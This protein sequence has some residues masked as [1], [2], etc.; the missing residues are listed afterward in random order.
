MRPPSARGDF[1]LPGVTL[2]HE[3]RLYCYLADISIH[4]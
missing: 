2:H 3:D 4:I 1:L